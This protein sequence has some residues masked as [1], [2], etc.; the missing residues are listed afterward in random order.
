MAE[1]S[2]QEAPEDIPPETMETNLSVASEVVMDSSLEEP[3]LQADTSA[4][5]SCGP[6]LAIK[7]KEIVSS[8]G[9]SVTASDGE[10]VITNSDVTYDQEGTCAIPEPQEDYDEQIKVP[11]ENVDLPM[12]GQS[13]VEVSLPSSQEME[14]EGSPPKERQEDVIEDHKIEPT[15]EIDFDFD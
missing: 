12:E 8:D 3:S 6:V 14:A 15:G 9:D 13:L 7:T 1:S 4:V 11:D 5:P 2:A 10:E